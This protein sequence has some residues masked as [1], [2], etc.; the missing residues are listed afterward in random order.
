MEKKQLLVPSITTNS[1]HRE[2]QSCPACGDRAIPIEQGC[3]FGN[4]RGPFPAQAP[5]WCKADANHQRGASTV[6]SLRRGS[7]W[8]P[9]E[10]T[11]PPEVCRGVMLCCQGTGARIC[12]PGHRDPLKTMHHQ[13]LLLLLPGQAHLPHK[14]SFEFRK[15]MREISFSCFRAERIMG[16]LFPSN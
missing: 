2:T 3:I 9:W 15:E 12:A 14:F 11:P 4:W 5:G 1:G 16:S 13:L 10:H 8:N 6:R 7:S